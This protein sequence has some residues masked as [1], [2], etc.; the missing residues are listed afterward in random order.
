MNTTDRYLEHNKRYVASR[1]P[2]ALPRPPSQHIAVISCM[3]SRLDVYAILGLH[4]GEAHVIRNAGGV[5]TDDALRSLLISQ[6]LL[7][8]TEIVLMHHTDCGMLTFT[9]E[10]LYAKIE[11]EVGV[12]PDFALESFTDLEEDVRKGMRRIAESPFIPHKGAMRGFIYDVATGGLAEV[13]LSGP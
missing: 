10:E 1:D 8:T 3:D 9:D 12:V 11:A 13:N 5:V 6:R 7:N 4:E 2:G